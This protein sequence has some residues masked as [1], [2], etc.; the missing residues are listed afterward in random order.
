MSSST[1]KYS[2]SN[3]SLDNLKYCDKYVS[4]NGEQYFTDFLEPEY[5]LLK[6]SYTRLVFKYNENIKK[7][8]ANKLKDVYLHFKVNVI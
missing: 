7:K 8:S 3:F 6:V 5:N 4:L 2:H 1:I